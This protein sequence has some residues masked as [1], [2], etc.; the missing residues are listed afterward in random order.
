MSDR[1]VSPKPTEDEGRFELSLRPKRLAEYIGQDKI[2]QNSAFADVKINHFRVQ[3][4][5]SREKEYSLTFTFRGM[6]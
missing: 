2:K 3:G 6:K 4:K 5:D 1:I